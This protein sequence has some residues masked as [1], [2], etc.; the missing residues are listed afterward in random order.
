MKMLSKTL[1]T[2]L[3]L[4]APM[5]VSAE[6]PKDKL[7]HVGASYAV[8]NVAYVFTQDP[9]KYSVA[10]MSVGLAKE[11]YDEYDY[12]GFDEKDLLA[13]AVGCAL[14][15]YFPLTKGLTFT[16]TGDNVGFNYK[17]SF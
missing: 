12:N 1:L 16:T 6:V 5:F 8:G 14:G 9:V 4:S 11:L 15:Y 2:S 17:M 7:L 3:L 10:C 13:D